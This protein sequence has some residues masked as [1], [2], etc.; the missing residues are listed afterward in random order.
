VDARTSLHL[1]LV[2][3]T[4]GLGRGGQ[5]QPSAVPTVSVAFSTA[6]SRMAGEAGHGTQKPRS[7]ASVSWA[8]RVSNLRPLACEAWRSWALQATKCLQTSP[9]RPVSR[10]PALGLIRPGPAG[11]DPTN[12]PTAGPPGEIAR[13]LGVGGSGR[14]QRAGPGDHDGKRIA[15]IAGL[16]PR[17]VSAGRASAPQF[18]SG[19]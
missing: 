18:R 12:G 4:V 1:A 17:L 9:K 7:G 11:F 16:R 19:S 2:V 3:V 15:S 14:H 6:G 8:R 5:H 13:P 10:C